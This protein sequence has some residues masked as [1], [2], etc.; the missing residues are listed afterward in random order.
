M[1]NVQGI[2][3]LRLATLA[4]S[5]LLACASACDAAA[6]DATPAPKA[7]AF[8][9]I[10]A[11]DGPPNDLTFLKRMRECGFTVAGFV[12]VAA[13]DNCQAAGLKGIVSDP[14]LG[15]YD[16]RNVDAAKARDNVTKVV[17]KVRNHPAVF[18]Y[19]LRDE[20]PAGFFPGLEKVASV[21]RELHPGVWPYINLFPTYAEAWQLETK[22]YETY[23]EQFIATCHPPVLS[24][25]HYAFMEGGGFSQAYYTN[26]EVM[27]RVALKHNLPFWNIVQGLGALN[28]R[29]PTHTDLRMQA[30]TSLA[31]GVHGLAWF[32]YSSSTT[33]N[34]RGAPI[35]GFGNET[36]TWKW[37][38]NVNLQ[39]A[40]LG[41]TML[42]LKSD[43]VYHFG[44][45]PP[46]CSGPDEHSLVKTIGGPMLVG[47]STHEDGTR[48]VMIVNKDF[49]GS[50]P[51][52]PQFRDSYKKVEQVSSYSGDVIG[53][54]GE[55]RWLAPGQGVL[56][57]LTK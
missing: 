26:L 12:P 52:G 42:K 16:W 29:E 35:D 54:E 25:D 28:F 37:M 14:G 5:I 1:L 6:A 34:F 20:P 11:W 49:N 46:G 23:L 44:T 30:Y 3:I 22:D 55:Q 43:R 27:R 47:D 57:K 19:Y 2:P 48:Y 4:A 18:G 51:A 38:Q 56:L 33:G 32:K 21:V 17:E 31:Y 45:V 36:Q 15:G 53:F 41:P 50:V 40:A 13:L 10:M 9:P 39:I 24:Y 8:F 7:A